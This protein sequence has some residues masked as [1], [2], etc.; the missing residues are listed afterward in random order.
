M[1]R[2]LRKPG[3]P[4]R[5]RLVSY[6]PPVRSI[7]PRQPPGRSASLPLFLSL[8]FAPLFRPPPQFSLLSSSLPLPLSSYLFP[9]PPPL[10]LTLFLPFILFHPS[11]NTPFPR[12]TFL[13]LLFLL[14]FHLLLPKPRFLLVRSL[15]HLSLSL[16]VC[17]P[18]ERLS[19]LLLL[20]LLFLV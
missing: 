6:R 16:F 7:T 13:L 17:I 4:R 2:H 5:R 12:S 14:L 20:L 8:H 15:C 9:P 18:Q 3:H 1:V 10:L 11:S 19:T